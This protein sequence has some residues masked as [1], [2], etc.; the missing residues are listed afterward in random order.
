[1][2]VLKTAAAIAVA[3]LSYRYFESPIRSLGRRWRRPA[4]AEVAQPATA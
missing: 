3:E 4:R 2:I 1:L